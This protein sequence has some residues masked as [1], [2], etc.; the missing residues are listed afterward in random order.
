MVV[1]MSGF[2]CNPLR[3]KRWL[4]HSVNCLAPGRS[5]FQGVLC[6]TEVSE[7]WNEQLQTE[8][9]V[10]RL[11]HW[12]KGNQRNTLLRQHAELAVKDTQLVQ[13]FVKA[14]MHCTVSCM[15]SVAGLTH[16]RAPRK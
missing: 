6:R 16:L 13:A 7:D 2:G 3:H 14:C 10:N 12:K 11:R 15:L 9:G 5:V 8:H 4:A 1:S